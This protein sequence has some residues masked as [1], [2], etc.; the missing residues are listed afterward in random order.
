MKRIALNIL[1]SLL[2]V[3]AQG[4][5]LQDALAQEDSL[6]TYREASRGG[7]GKFYL[8]REIA[9]VMG[10]SNAEWLDR[11]SRPRGKYP[12]DY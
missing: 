8:G 9:H 2:V 3:S 7:T 6:Y 12:V 10:A 11:S 1:I 5:A 4:I